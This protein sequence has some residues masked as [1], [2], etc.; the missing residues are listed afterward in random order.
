M[1]SLKK[2][3]ICLCLAAAGMVVFNGCHT[4]HGFGKDVENAGEN[5]QDNT[6]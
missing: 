3:I 4:A 6:P 5:I 1:K 2:T